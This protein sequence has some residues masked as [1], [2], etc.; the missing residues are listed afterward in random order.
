MEKDRPGH[1]R[2]YELIGEMQRIHDKKNNDYAGNETP[3][4]NLLE[5]K[6]IGIDPFKGVLVR[7]SDKW[8]RICRLA[9]GVQPQVKDESIKDTLLDIAN[10]A[11]FAI[12]ILEEAGE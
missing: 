2:F 8:S 7:M 3:L 12:I 6:K 9:S 10:Y 11:L 4:A 5:C 1:P